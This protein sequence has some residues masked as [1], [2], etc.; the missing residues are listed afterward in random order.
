VNPRKQL[1]GR[2][3]WRGF[4]L[5]NRAGSVKSWTTQ[6]VIADSGKV[7]MVKTNNGGYGSV[8]IGDGEEWADISFTSAGV[9]TLKASSANVGTTEDNDTTFNIYDAGGRIGFN[10]ELGTAKN[11]LVNIWWS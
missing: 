3:W 7:L 4:T 2:L 11:I 9:V 8:L 6:E 5:F 10:N 1:K